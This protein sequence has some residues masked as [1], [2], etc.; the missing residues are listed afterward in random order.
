M[1]DALDT[2]VSVSITKESAKLTRAGFSKPMILGVHTNFAD[3]WKDYSS[4]AELITDGFLTS[5]AI[6]KAAAAILAQN[7]KLKT[8]RV[9]KAS[10]PVA[11]VSTVTIASVANSTDYAVTINGVEYEITS[12][13][14]AVNTEIR[15][16]LVAEINADAS[17]PV[18]AAPGGATTLTLTADN[19]GAGFNVSVTPTILTVAAT[20]PNNG[21][22]EDILSFVDQADGDN[23]YGL[24]LS[25]RNDEV[26]WWVAQT[27]ETLRK[28]FLFVTTD[29]DVVDEAYSSTTPTDVP[30]RLKAASLSRTA[31]IYHDDAAEYP[32]AAWMGM[33]FTKTPGSATW[34]FK[35]PVGI[36]PVA[37]STSQ[38]NNLKAKS[39]NWFET[40]AG[41][42]IM[43][44]GT[45]AVGEFIDIVHGTDALTLRLMEDVFAMLAKANKVPYTI[46]GLAMVATAM[47]PGLEA[48][49]A[50]GLIAAEPKYVITTPAIEDI[51]TNDKEAR[52]LNNVE[53]TATY[54]GAVHFVSIA[55]TLSF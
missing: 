3:D 31:A 5:D 43:A 22:A 7:P 30:S 16:A 37:V 39:C 49:E 18:T 24:I 41:L 53:F 45:V 36:T 19:A 12:D 44:E 1:S 26:S 35:T 50:S 38:R 25:A 47:R 2:I 27:I 34:K 20:T 13:G 46:S 11:Q 55:G 42:S 9:G 14:T 33:M 51:S 15:D 40:I 29:A 32:D 4:L 6:Y 48:Y 10:T 21:P 17:C 23:W 54:A 52:E 28:L 8:F